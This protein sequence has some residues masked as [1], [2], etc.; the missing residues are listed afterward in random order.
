MRDKMT[1]LYK[2]NIAGLALRF[3]CAVLLLGLPIAVAQD[4]PEASPQADSVSESVDAET[5]SGD[6][7]ASEKQ[8][9][10]ASSADSEGVSEESPEAPADAKLEPVSTDGAA[11]ALYVIDLIAAQ[12]RAVSDNPSIAAGAERVQQVR[13]MVTQARSLYFPL[14]DMSYT[15]TLSWLPSGYTDSIYSYLDQSED[16]LRDWRK[17]SI[18]QSTITRQPAVRN[19]QNIRRWYG[20]TQDLIQETRENLESPVDNTTMG[21]TV[22]WLLF[23]GFAR[24]FANAM[25]KYGYR[26]AQAAFREGQRILLDA[27]AQAYYGAQIAREQIAIAESE[28]SFYERLHKE[29]QARRE[30]GRGATSHVLSF[31]T[32]LYAARANRL[33]SLRDFEMAKV[34]LAMLLAIPEGRLD[35]RFELAELEEET[36]ETLSLPDEEAMVSLAYAHRPDL[37]QYELGLKRAQA[38][39]KREYASFAP[40]IAAVGQLQTTNVNEGGF[41]PDRI[42]TTV[43]LNASLNLF[44][45]GRRRASVIEAK[46]ARREAELRI[47]EAEQKVMSDVCQAMTDLKIAQEALTLQREAAVCVEKNRDLVELEYNAGKAMLVSLSQA[48]RDYMQAAGMFA[49]ARVNLQRTWQALHAATGTNLT[50]LSQEAE[51]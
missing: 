1:V 19:R 7:E 21:M 11:E 13:Q 50:V 3:V 5:V 20:S 41:D 43:G 25:A 10:D 18:L 8:S 12:R 6:K 48:Q 45:G 32:L 39:V 46:H 40:Q 42:T 49:Q 51:E 31:Q 23:D 17:E 38:N 24:E 29:A 2:K 15:Y 9:V 47:V 36:P 34:I 22:G 30:V 26:E 27:V 4:I 16:M 44:S 33:R 28:I 35:D 14:I 37:E